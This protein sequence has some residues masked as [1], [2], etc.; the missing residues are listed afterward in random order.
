MFTVRHIA[1]A[2]GSFALSASLC[3]AQN[4]APSHSGTVD[5]FEGEVSIDGLQIVSQAARFSTLKEQNVLKTGLGRAEILLTPGVILRVGANSSIRMLDSN[6]MHTQVQLLSGTAMV[7]AAE[8][9]TDVKDPPVT[10]FYNG[11]QAQ[12][13]KYG[14][15]EISSDP[16]QVRVYKGEAR[17][18]KGNDDWKNVKDGNQISLTDNEKMAT[19]K[20]DDKVADDLF[21]WSRDRSSYLAA[22]NISSARTLSSANRTYG[23]YGAL[24]WNSAMWSGFSGGWYFN[25]YL[26]MFS[27][28]PFGGMMMSP[29]GY[30]YFN[31]F[32]VGYFYNTPGYYWSGAG[33]AR[34]GTTAGVPLSSAPTKTL[35]LRTGSSAPQ[36]PRL[37]T[38]ATLR[39]TVNSPLRGALRP[40]SGGAN[41]GGRNTGLFA[42]RNGG[43]Q[44]AF[45]NGINN[46]N[47]NISR[48][49]AMSSAPAMSAPAAAPAPMAAPSAGARVGGMRR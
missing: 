41:L 38:T 33:G 26:N 44:P 40:S 47:N 31:P 18:S 12:P 5:Y 1:V 10:I 28:M 39:P 4:V 25:P 9:D 27:F 8:S 22:A 20:F 48:G 21:L 29:F 6:L 7:E 13:V 37:G 15:F 30:D 32:T 45:N 46:G 16:A 36:L 14:I 49:P 35:G 24:G 43:N 42:G 17:V 11:N 23:G 3:L 19:S 34:T 2:L